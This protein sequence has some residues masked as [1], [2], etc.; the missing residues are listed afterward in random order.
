[1]SSERERGL[2]LHGLAALLVVAGGIWWWRAAPRAESDP[3]MLNWRLA[4]EQLLPETEE[5]EKSDTLA[6][7]AED[8]FST[9]ED[10]TGGAFLVSVVCAGPDGS[11]VRVSLGDDESGR[12]LPCSGPRTPEVFSVAVGTRL[13]LRVVA[14]ES[15]PLVFRY[16]L[17][18]DPN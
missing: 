4:A 6:L 3:R 17:Q 1:M 16:T 2:I 13:F 18:R 8:E 9:V 7:N 11:R 14:D 10:L 15:G 5:Q 12:G